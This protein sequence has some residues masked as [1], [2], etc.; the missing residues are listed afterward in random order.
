M[1]NPMYNSFRVQMLITILGVLLI[2]FFS[3]AYIL[4]ST[5]RLQKVLDNS[6]VQQR[7]LKDMQN[8]LDELQIPFLEY[9]S[10]KSSN[11][12]SELLILSQKIHEAIPVYH[13]V[14]TNLVMLHEKELYEIV[15]AYLDLADMVIEEKRG[16]D[17][18]RYTSLYDEMQVWSAYIHTQIESI[19][20]TRFAN[21]LSEYEYFIETS[22]R[23]QFWN[24]MFI[25]FISLFSLL[26]LIKTVEKINRPMVNLSNM[27]A[28]LSMGNF[29][30]EDI[31]MTH[32][33]E[34][35]RVVSAFNRMKKD[36][37]TYI[38][39][40]KWQR[41]VEKDYMQERVRNMKMEHMLRKMELYTM[42]AQMNPHFLFNTLNTGI[43]LAIV[44]GAERTGAYMEHLSKLFRHNL[45]EKNVIVPL[46]HEIEG[47]E[48][49]FYILG[50]RF[51][52]NL[53]LV[54][55]CPAEILDIY[56][57]PAS[58]LQPLVENCVVHAFKNREG[59]NS[60]VVRVYCAENKLCLSVADNG[61]GMKEST[62]AS[63]L[64]NPRT[65]ESGT[66]VMGLENV[67]QRLYFFFPDDPDV[68]T[69]KAK[70][71]EGTEILIKI[72]TEK[73]LCIPS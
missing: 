46:R 56:H 36:I 9:L 71:D 64:T 28:A 41:N 21:Q 7:Y 29:D 50:V 19:S 40:I 52:R 63:L 27:A 43:Q 13:S 1:K 47:L 25:L 31:G 26:M 45:R 69:I 15:R 2:L 54:L 49:Y 14:P 51:P 8:H 73:E 37:H 16:M 39:E 44:E 57:I 66:K 67:I 62:V 20:S 58:V 42:Q 72:D 4:F 24:L 23:I 5:I 10:S 3:A 32:L 65:H 53:D 22:G 59:I 12:L 17:I 18:T 11:A 38:E 61:S 48:S 70:K 35:D 33:Y 55:D 30:V 6:F 60:I 34:I 68:I